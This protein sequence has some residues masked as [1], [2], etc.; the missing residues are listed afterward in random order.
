M[1]G[2][3]KRYKAPEEEGGG[4]QEGGFQHGVCP[5]HNSLGGAQ[6]TKREKQLKAR[7]KPR[8]PNCE[9]LRSGTRRRRR[10]KKKKKKEVEEEEGRKA[11][12]RTACVP[13]TTRLPASTKLPRG[14]RS[15]WEWR[16]TQ[17]SC[18]I[19]KESVVFVPEE[20]GR[21]LAE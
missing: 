2:P 16:R 15:P 4:G 9:D 18:N 5:L 17:R 3:D 10:E 6:E 19:D 12:G 20:E 14:V 1:W 7:N 21:R 11:G 13:S 8:K